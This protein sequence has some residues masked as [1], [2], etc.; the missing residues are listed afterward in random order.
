MTDQT[1]VLVEK[2]KSKQFNQFIKMFKSRT[3]IPTAEIRSKI[4]KSSFQELILEKIYELN[5]T[6]SK[7]SHDSEPFIVPILYNKNGKVIQAFQRRSSIEII[8][9]DPNY[10]HLKINRQ[11]Q[12]MENFSK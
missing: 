4:A 12:S 5:E 11:N 3:E 8:D 6:I 1:I 7:I 2:R 10:F 9:D